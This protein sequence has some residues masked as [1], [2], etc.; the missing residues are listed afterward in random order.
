MPLSDPIQS[1]EMAKKQIP[2]TR[3]RIFGPTLWPVHRGTF[4]WVV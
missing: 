2:T 4:A 3:R 1:F